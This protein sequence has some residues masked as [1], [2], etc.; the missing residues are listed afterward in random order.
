MIKL[1]LSDNVMTLKTRGMRNLNAEISRFK[2]S[3]G[4]GIL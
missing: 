2:M 1:L 3:N 4:R